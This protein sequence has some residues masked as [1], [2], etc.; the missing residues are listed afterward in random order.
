MAFPLSY[1]CN[2]YNPWLMLVFRSGFCFC[3]VSLEEKGR[4]SPIFI[5]MYV[6]IL[7]SIMSSSTSLYCVLEQD[8]NSLL[9]TGLTQEDPSQHNWITDVW[10]I[11]NQTKQTKQALDFSR[12]YTIAN[13]RFWAN[14]SICKTWFCKF[15][16]LGGDAFTR[17]CIIS[18]LTL[19]LGQW[20]TR[21]VAKYPLHQITYS[22]AKFEVAMSNGVGGNAFTINI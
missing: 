17:K 16:R 8:N 11:K 5:N 6:F 14:Q 18:L 1:I 3:S 4:I 21:N 12:L 22:S 10:D 19:T 15:D 7:T 13:T 20:Q 2:S 9:S